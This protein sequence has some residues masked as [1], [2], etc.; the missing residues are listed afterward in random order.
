MNENTTN[1]NEVNTTAANETTVNTEATAAATDPATAVANNAADNGNFLS[2]NK[3]LFIKAGIGA[4]VGLGAGFITWR[5]MKKAKAKKAETAVNEP[6]DVAPVES[7]VTN[8]N[9]TEGEII[10]VIDATV[11]I[12]PQA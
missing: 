8:A 10:D 6:A 5:V 9:T 4:V 3:G 11:T 12:E 7:A 2:R 1:I